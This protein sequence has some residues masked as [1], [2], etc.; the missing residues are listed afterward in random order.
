MRARAAA[1]AS[2]VTMTPLPAA[3][4]SSL[5]TNGGPN[6]A[7]AASA[8]AG[9]VQ[10]RAAAV[11]MPPSAMTCLANALEPSIMAAARAGPKHAIPASRTASAAPA[12]SGTSGPITTRS[13]A[14]S[15]ASAAMA[16]GSDAVTGWVCA[17][18]AIPGLPG[19]ACRLVTAGSWARARTMACSRPPEPMTRTRT[20]ASLPADF[21][22]GPAHQISS[23]I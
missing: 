7:S 17:S 2:S 5:T 6:S 10:V 11:G 12:T 20:A 9:V 14:S 15:P 13:A 22:V 21:V 18:A 4:P 8:S 1:S 16:A 19:A 3:S 23:R